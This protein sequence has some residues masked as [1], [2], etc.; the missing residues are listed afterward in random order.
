MKKVF[1]LM[2]FMLLLVG[3]GKDGESLPIEESIQGGDV[4][5]IPP[6]ESR[7][8][9][10]D[11]FIKGDEEV[12]ESSEDFQESL[13]SQPEITESSEESVPEGSEEDQSSAEQ[14][15][16]SETDIQ[17]DV[18]DWVEGPIEYGVEYRNEETGEVYIAFD[19]NPEVN[20][21]F[22][23]ESFSEVIDTI[24]EYGTYEVSSINYEDASITENLPEWVRNIYIF[25][26]DDWQPVF[27]YAL[28]LK[29]YGEGLE[30]GE[31]EATSYYHYNSGDYAHVY[32]IN[33]VD[34]CFVFCEDNSVVYVYDLALEGK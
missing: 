17:L 3:C 7:E 28:A 25:Y 6:G 23:R 8:T 1:M 22:V 20:T 27:C 4:E 12:A 16:M 34:V 31:T 11:K 13:E 2:M 5:I 19:P 26:P 18:P 10:Y 32:S 29:L 33:G 14:P 21:D 9:D 30:F 15:S 24:S